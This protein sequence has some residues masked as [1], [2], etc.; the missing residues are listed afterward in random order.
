M[1][2]V[3]RIRMRRWREREFVLNGEGDEDCLRWVG[4][5]RCRRPRYSSVFL[6]SLYWKALLL[7]CLTSSNWVWKTWDAEV[8]TRLEHQTARRTNSGSCRTGSCPPLTLIGW[9]LNSPFSPRRVGAWRYFI[10]QLCRLSIH[11]TKTTFAKD[12]KHPATALQSSLLWICKPFQAAAPPRAPWQD[13][14]YSNLDT[15]ITE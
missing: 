2:W 10:A 7:E 9:C 3:C 8:L 4:T 15:R 12:S 6:H 13:R 11:S 14:V 1:H 5:G